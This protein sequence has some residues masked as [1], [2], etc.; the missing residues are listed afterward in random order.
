[1]YSLNSNIYY[2]IDWR[3][4]VKDEDI[5]TGLKIKLHFQIML[6]I[7]YSESF[8]STE[9]FKGNFDTR[10]KQSTRNM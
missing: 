8:I 10:R 1:M 6:N 3:L 7:T 4:Q 2:V 5:Q 9:R